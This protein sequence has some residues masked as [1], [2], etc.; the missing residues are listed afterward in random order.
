[1]GHKI[2]TDKEIEWAYE[3]WCNGM[4]LLQIADALY[5]NERTVRRA[6]N[7]RPRIRPVLKKESE[8]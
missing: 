3:Q 5:V 6:F 2:L 7:G 8:K 1:M 4:T